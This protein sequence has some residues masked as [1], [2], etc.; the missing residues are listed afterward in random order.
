VGTEQNNRTVAEIAEAVVDAVPGSVL[1]ITGE[2]GPDPRSYR[3]DFSRARKVLDFEGQWTIPAGA[4]ELAEEYRF[5]NLTQQGFEQRFTRLAVLSSR[6]AEGSL[7][8]DMRPA[9]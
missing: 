4:R 7:D 8:A 1:E 9:G 5:R 2:A 6:Q 3:V